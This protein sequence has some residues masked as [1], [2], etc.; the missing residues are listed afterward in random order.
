MYEDRM[1]EALARRER[2]RRNYESS[3]IER[4]STNARATG[5]YFRFPEAWPVREAL[6]EAVA[7]GHD[8]ELA[9]AVLMAVRACHKE[10][11][12]DRQRSGRA[13]YDYMAR[14][15]RASNAKAMRRQFTDPAIKQLQALILFGYCV[16][17]GSNR[18]SM[19][20]LG[21]LFSAVLFITGPTAYW[22]SLPR[23]EVRRQLRERRREAEI[24][25]LRRMR[26][27]KARQRI[28]SDSELASR[29]LSVLEEVERY[30]S[31]RRNSVAGLF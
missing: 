12:S 4:L 1:R 24:Y 10:I 17:R 18:F 23:D 31:P 9:R 28:E 15:N 19:T 6:R 11:G 20:A 13:W 22:K 21:P 2:F 5:L 30:F 27:L 7:R 29:A 26:Q 16:R 3:P 8:H 25:L 14:Q